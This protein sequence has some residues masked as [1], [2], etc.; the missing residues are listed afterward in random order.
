[1]IA[2][3]SNDVT[4][5]NI[6]LRNC[7]VL[8]TRAHQLYPDGNIPVYLPELK[9]PRELKLHYYKKRTESRQLWFSRENF[10]LYQVQVVSELMSATSLSVHVSWLDVAL[11]NNTPGI[12]LSWLENIYHTLAVQ[13]PT[14][15]AY[16]YGLGN[17]RQ[18]QN[19]VKEA[20]IAWHDALKFF[21]DS[22][23]LHYHLARSCSDTPEDATRAMSHLRWM[24]PRVKSP[25]WKAKVYHHMA[26]RYS[27]LGDFTNGYLYAERAAK[28]VAHEL[29]NESKALF[30][31]AKRTK[32]SA[33]LRMGR[34]E[35]AVVALE[36]AVLTAPKNLALK[37]ELADMFAG[38]AVSEPQVNK[39][40]LKASFLWYDTILRDNPD[41]PMI[42]ASKAF[43]YLRNGEI[44]KAQSE[45]VQ[46]I[47]VRPDSLSALTTLGFTYL[48]QNKL[49]E[50]RV[51]FKKA[52][53]FDPECSA[54]LKGLDAVAK[55]EAIENHT[56][57]HQ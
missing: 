32:C 11:E 38:L 42:H 1:M 56:Q 47:T 45:A 31:E 25:V 22:I 18:L 36:E 35:A 14:I 23:Y 5:M 28:Q 49:T 44:M 12:S 19:K 54:A 50:A 29:S 55:A 26:I 9:N 6:A 16:W 24:A 10:S 37:M 34:Q 3:E 13:E 4:G 20:N 53:D 21:P 7:E 48:S 39:K 33:L 52:L 17:S 51:L 40:Y 2:S 30:V 57:Q 43:L 41:L 8:F 15:F 27:Q 46:E